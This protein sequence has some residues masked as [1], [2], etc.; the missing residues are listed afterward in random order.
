MTEP[1]EDNDHPRV[2]LLA[3]AIHGVIG[4]FVASGSVTLTSPIVFRH[5]TIKQKGEFAPIV[6]TSPVR[7]LTNTE[8]AR[9]ATIKRLM[10]LCK[11]APYGEGGK[12]KINPEV[13]KAKQLRA[14]DGGFAI[15]G[16]DPEALG[17]LRAAQEVLAPEDPN[18]IRAVFYGL[19]V[20][21]SGGHF[22][23]HKDTP[24]GDDMVGTLVA[25]LPS[26]YSGGTL[27][28]Q[29]QGIERR[30]FER[31]RWGRE[32]DL[33]GIQWAAFFGD[34]DH[35][36]ER[37]H[38]GERVT[39]TWSLHRGEGGVARPTLAG[40]V[41]DRLATALREAHA[42]ASF[43]EDGVTLG[44]LCSHRYAHGIHAPVTR[45]A[46]TATTALAL[47]GRDQQIALAAIDAGL[48]V[49]LRPLIAEE[50]AEQVWPLRRFLTRADEAMFRQVRLRASEIEAR[51]E[52]AE[53]IEF[54]SNGLESA[55]GLPDYWLARPNQIGSSEGGEDSGMP[56]WRLLGETEYSA[57]GYFGNEGGHTSFYAAAALVITVPSTEAR[58]R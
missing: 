28:V 16:L 6:E 8:S 22:V 12:T 17:I 25:L 14:G 33:N 49:V 20:Y 39:L 31:T 29:H 35:K 58:A 40:T 13:R 19:N 43:F 50:C 37:V 5:A 41:R 24:R 34:V 36:I 21:E 38:S 18:A 44:L 45:H 48:E 51:I 2:A 55:E 11:S 10:K 56:A 57:T 23:A 4:E 47:K 27:C 32:V 3:Q 15:E 7:D 9:S 30:F 54:V 26:R 52:L 1:I 42:D 46:L 53:G